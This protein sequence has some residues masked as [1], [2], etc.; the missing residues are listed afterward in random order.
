MDAQDGTSLCEVSRFQ[1]SSLAACQVSATNA[2]VQ[3]L[4][5]TVETETRLSARCIRI[6]HGHIQGAEIAALYPNAIALPVLLVLGY[7]V[8]STSLVVMA[9]RVQSSTHGKRLGPRI[10]LLTT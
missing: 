9:P 7:P 10:R 4:E 5:I 3:R 1:I 2:L 6:A 8:A